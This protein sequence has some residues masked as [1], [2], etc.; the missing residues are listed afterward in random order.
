MLGIEPCPRCLGDILVEKDGGSVCIHCGQR[1]AALSPSKRGS[2]AV[3]QSVS[4]L[5]L[6]RDVRFDAAA[7][8]DLRRSVEVEFVNL[9]VTGAGVNFELG[10]TILERKASAGR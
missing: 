1:R 5:S 10:A 4:W 3:T 9:A 2:P 6:P 8:R 7:D